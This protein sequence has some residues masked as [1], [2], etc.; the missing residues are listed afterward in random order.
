MTERP[1]R[2]GAGPGVPDDEATPES[3]AFDLTPP[4]LKPIQGAQ[5][6]TLPEGDTGEEIA[7]RRTSDPDLPPNGE[8]D[9]R[10]R[11]AVEAARLAAEERATAEILALEEDLEQER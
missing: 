8:R 1:P 9:E 11:Q 4:Q 6:R 3:T 7:I 5:A 2:K 10:M